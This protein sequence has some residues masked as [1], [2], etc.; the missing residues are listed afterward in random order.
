MIKHN[1]NQRYATDAYG[2]AEFGAACAAAEVPVQEYSHRNDI[3]CGST[4]GPVVAARLAMRTVDVGMPQLSMHSVR[5]LMAVADVDHMTRSFSA[6][7][8]G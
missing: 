3:P 8:A 1:A 7:F 6:W 5:E 2:A 4:I